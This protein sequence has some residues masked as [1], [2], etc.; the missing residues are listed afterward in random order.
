MELQEFIDTNDD[1]ISQFKEHK[2]YVRNYT[3]LGLLIV[4]SNR[5]TTYDYINHPWLSYCRGAIINTKTKRVCV[6]VAEVRWSDL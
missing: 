5:K 1:Y 3:R 2:L 4:K 6:L